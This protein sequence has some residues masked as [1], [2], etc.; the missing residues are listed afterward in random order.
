MSSKLIIYKNILW[1]LLGGV[2]PILVA[3][4]TIPPL[5]IELGNEL[6]GVLAIGW[7]LMG[8]FVLS[9]LG[10]G[11][12]TKKYISG[13]GSD[14][15][16][17]SSCTLVW[18]S[19]SMLLFLGVVASVIFVVVTP[20][21]VRDAFK[22][23]IESQAE[24][25]SAFIWLAASISPLL[26]TSGLR[27]ILEGRRRFDLTNLLKIPAGLIN[28]LVPYIILSTTNDVSVMMFFIFLGRLVMLLA[29]IVVA[30][31]VIPE[32][33]RRPRVGMLSFLSLLNFGI[34]ATASSLILP[35]Y[36]V[37]DRLLVASLFGLAS[38]IYY[39]TPYEVITK[40]WIISASVMGVM[41]P[42]MSAS[43]ARSEE[44]AGLCRNS[45]I[46][47]LGAALPLTCILILYS[48]D[49]LGFWIS[50]DLA[51]QSGTVAKWLA[52]GVFVNILGQIPL[53]A[54]QASGR[55]DIVAKVQILMLPFFLLLAWEL[56]KV[57]GTVGVA[58]A[59][60]I[61][62]IS[63]GLLL[64]LLNE[65]RMRARAKLR[66]LELLNFGVI[67]LFLSICW[68]LEKI[69]REWLDL[70]LWAG[71]LILILLMW[72]YWCYLLRTEERAHFK[73][74]SHFLLKTK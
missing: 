52:V 41:F 46:I 10:I 69:G 30:R 9:D 31:N 15:Q 6:F 47:V 12:A 1:S 64:V 11:L 26:I 38:A 13:L 50:T 28:Y 34:W 22:V 67:V 27:N 43:P 36:L 74:F 51:E 16:T 23:S 37:A 21:L 14:T 29:H 17:D 18:T 2:A 8:Y 49:I 3:I 45:F 63:E 40:L 65:K 58:M 60:A 39:M 4:F 68:G 70:R 54:L 32:L 5:I 61:R 73:K 44:M 25:E 42:L 55:P 48:R 59:W 72:W 20:D 33:R 66:F 19:I 35:I 7:L 71:G 62:A 56:S 24:A 57:E 53:T